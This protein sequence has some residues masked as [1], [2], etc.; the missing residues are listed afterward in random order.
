M[1][2]ALLKAFLILRL[3]RTH[4]YRGAVPKFEVKSGIGWSCTEVT[5][6]ALSGTAAPILG[7]PRPNATTS[8]S[9]ISASVGTRTAPDLSSYNRWRQGRADGM[10]R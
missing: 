8:G 1:L 7:A 9:S 5:L 6:L 4:S 3:D 2:Q 10:N